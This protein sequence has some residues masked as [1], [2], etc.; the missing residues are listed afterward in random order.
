M[1]IKLY[2]ISDDAKTVSKTLGAQ[3]IIATVNGT[4]KNDCDILRPTIELTYFSQISQAN[5]MYISD[6][7]R[8]YFLEKPTVSA[9]RCYIT[10]RVDVLTSF[11]SEIKELD[12]IVERQEK[13]PNYN[14]Y[15]P[16]KY[17]KG[18]AYKVIKTF[19]WSKGFDK[20]H[21]SLILTTGGRS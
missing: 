18:L 17:F 15:L 4:I 14:L 16:D 7:G 19:R 8:Y 3:Q 20:D 1:E 13:W 6:W 12:C 2:K 10:G 21:S 5:Y 11:A 9:Q